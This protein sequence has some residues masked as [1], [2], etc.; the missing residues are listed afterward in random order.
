LVAATRESIIS[1]V[2][3]A[4]NFSSNFASR[5]SWRIDMLLEQMAGP[6]VTWN[7]QR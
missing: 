1:E 4:W 2:R 3:A 5:T 7:E 6:F